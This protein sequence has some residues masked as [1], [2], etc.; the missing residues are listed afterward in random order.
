MFHATVS[1]IR[2]KKTKHSHLKTL[3][4]RA[5]YQALAA[6]LKKN[7]DEAILLNARKE[8]V[9]CSRSNIFLVK[10]KRIF[11]PPISSGCLEGTTRANVLALARKNK[12]SCRESALNL[13]DLRRADEVFVTN[14]VIG[15]VPLT[16]VDGRAIASGKAGPLTKKIQTAYRRS[17]SE[18]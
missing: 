1:K 13:K 3:D 8:L 4:Y 5:C 7:L 17:I 14:A 12:I 15:V 9:E 11:T 18:R 2:R 10:D 16:K 6:A